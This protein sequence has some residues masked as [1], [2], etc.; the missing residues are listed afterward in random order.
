MTN[1]RF[2]GS[3]TH[4]MLFWKDSGQAH[5]SLIY[6]AGSPEVARNAQESIE[7]EKAIEEYQKLYAKFELGRLEVGDYT[8]ENFKSTS[9]DT[10]VR[11]KGIIE[12]VLVDLPAN[13]TYGLTYAG[14]VVTKV[15]L[16]LGAMSLYKMGEGLVQGFYDG[17]GLKSPGTYFDKFL[18]LLEDNSKTSEDVYFSKLTTEFGLGMTAL[19][20][21]ADNSSDVN[22]TKVYESMREKMNVLSKA[23]VLKRMHRYAIANGGKGIVF[24][25]KDYKLDIGGKKTEVFPEKDSKDQPYKTNLNDLEALSNVVIS[26]FGEEGNKSYEQS[27]TLKNFLA[28]EIQRSEFEASDVAEAIFLRTIFADDKGK[29]KDTS[30]ITINGETYPLMTWR[31]LCIAGK[32]EIDT[33][34]SAL[35]TLGGFDLANVGGVS[36]IDTYF[37]YLKNQFLRKYLKGDKDDDAGAFLRG[38]YRKI[39]A[40]SY[41]PNGSFEIKKDE[42]WKKFEKYPELASFLNLYLEGT[43]LDGEKKEVLDMYDER[44]WKLVETTATTYNIIRF[45]KDISK[46]NK[47]SFK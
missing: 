14:T 2:N 35:A 17:L 24:D 33:V 9:P 12:T 15:S 40:G 39:T 22:F 13:L 46:Y 6:L 20:E 18:N 26:T 34:M 45:E 36:S 43:A 21:W 47:T 30:K 3:Q 5:G 38:E 11:D 1:T 25:G 19:K 28:P 37:H 41:N 4:K 16:E 42:F 29:M 7:H 8:R 31:A 44:M 10:S 32:T 27:N 23:I